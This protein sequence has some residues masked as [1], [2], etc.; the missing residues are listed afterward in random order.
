MLYAN[1]V[2]M[3]DKERL[4]L[5]IPKETNDQLKA[6]IDRTNSAS[7]TEVI[8]KALALLDAAVSAAERGH[9]VGAAEVGQVLVTEF[10]G[11]R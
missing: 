5:E 8:R 10:V 11:L 2:A 7:K 6:L 9:K 1:E 4:T 3:S